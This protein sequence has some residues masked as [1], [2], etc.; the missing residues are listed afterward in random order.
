MDIITIEITLLVCGILFVPSLAI[1]G[2]YVNNQKID[3]ISDPEQFKNITLN[4]LFNKRVTESYVDKIWK[5]RL[6]LSTSTTEMPTTS[7]IAFSSIKNKQRNSTKV[8]IK[9]IKTKNRLNISS[10]LN[11][12]EPNFVTETTTKRP[13]L[14]N[15]YRPKNKKKNSSKVGEIST[16]RHTP[17]IRTTR[18]IIKRRE[19]T[20]KKPKKRKT[21]KPKDEIVY[22]DVEEPS[23]VNEVSNAME[24]VYNFMEN[25]F[26]EKEYVPVTPKYKRSTIGT[27]KTN[28]MTTKIHVTSE[29]QG[30]VSTTPMTP[31]VDFKVDTSSES[32]FDY[33]DGVSVGSVEYDGE[34]YEIEEDE[35]YDEIEKLGKSNEKVKKKKIKK[36][37]KKKKKRPL[38]A[39]YEGDYSFEYDY[40]SFPSPQAS[41][42]MSNILSSIGRFAASLGFG[43]ARFGG[44]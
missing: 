29:Y 8:Q 16:T 20:K 5:E 24:N 10:T 17:T 38:S 9:R 41:G 26:V 12:K 13:S 23:G 2:L 31:Y 15:G 6:K 25:L 36:K 1:N 27:G 7:N 34:D 18:S 40:P 44:K 28:T 43:R 21:N 14:I 35:D 42:F 37:S 32:G 19:V 3:N 22:V 39:S 11:N 30:P 33:Y 4:G